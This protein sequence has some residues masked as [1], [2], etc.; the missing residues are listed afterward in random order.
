SLLSAN[1]KHSEFKSASELLD[2]FER[3]PLRPPVIDLSGGQP[4]LVPEWCLWFADELKNRGLHE[5]IYLWSDDNLSNDYLWRFLSASQIK[6][7]AS[8][9][10][11]GRVGCFKG[12][13]EESFSFNTL[14]QPSL[15]DRQF[16][17][18]RK[19]VDDKFDVYG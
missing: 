6:R 12:F 11:Y 2:L 5:H 3:E 15:F 13:D 14:A 17:L 10:N 4:D 1:P 9:N 8:Y 7:L 16:Q 18:M 19:I